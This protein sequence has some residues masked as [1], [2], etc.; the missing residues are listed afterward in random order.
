M[1]SSSEPEG[2]VLAPALLAVWYSE[3]PDSC[4]AHVIGIVNLGLTCTT[5]RE[6]P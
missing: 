6:Q 5:A 1:P 2:Y 3:R 4:S